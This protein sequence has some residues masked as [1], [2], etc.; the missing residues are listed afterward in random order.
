MKR[1]QPPGPKPTPPPAPPP[2][3]PHSILIEAIQREIDKYGVPTLLDVIA[4]LLRD[5]AADALTTVETTYWNECATQVALCVRAT[6]RA[7][8]PRPDSLATQLGER[9]GSQ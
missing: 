1:K 9:F 3:D 7:I 8:K 6:S 5:R 2:K 4:T